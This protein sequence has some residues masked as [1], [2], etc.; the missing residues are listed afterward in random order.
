VEREASRVRPL[1]QLHLIVSEMIDE[2]IRVLVAAMPDPTPGSLLEELFN[3][4]V[5]KQGPRQLHLFCQ[6]ANLA[7]ESFWIFGLD[8][9]PT[10]ASKVHRAKMSMARSVHGCVDCLEGLHEN[11][12]KE[13]S[14]RYEKRGIAP[15]TMDCI[16]ANIVTWMVEQT[17]QQIQNVRDSLTEWTTKS[18]T[19]GKEVKKLLKN[20]AVTLVWQVLNFPQHSLIDIPVDRDFFSFALQTLIRST[21]VDVFSSGILIGLG[22]A[23]YRIRDWMRSKMPD[24]NHPHFQWVDLKPGPVQIFKS[25]IDAMLNTSKGI[26][27]PNRFPHQFNWTRSPEAQWLALE[28]ILSL[29]PKPQK[30]MPNT[31]LANVLFTDYEIGLSII[32]L[33][34][35]LPSNMSPTFQL[36]VLNVMNHLLVGVDREQLSK[37][38]E[39]DMDTWKAVM[40][41]PIVAESLLSMTDDSKRNLVIFITLKYILC[42]T[43]EQPVMASQLLNLLDNP[44]TYFPITRSQKAWI[45]GIV[46]KDITAKPKE[47]LAG[48]IGFLAKSVLLSLPSQ[49]KE[50]NDTINAI[51]LIQGA[52]KRDAKRFGDA[53]IAHLRTEIFTPPEVYASDLWRLLKEHPHTW[54]ME[55]FSV[56]LLDAFKDLAIIPN[57][58]NQMLHTMEVHLRDL[59]YSVTNLFPDLGWNGYV[60]MMIPILVTNNIDIRTLAIKHATTV[61]QA[62]NESMAIRQVV[63][64]APDAAWN[65]VA[66]QCKTLLKLFNLIP[67]EAMDYGLQVIQMIHVMARYHVNALSEDNVK[68]LCKLLVDLL[69]IARS[70]HIEPEKATAPAKFALRIL[71]T[72]VK[73][74][75]MFVEQIGFDEMLVHTSEVAK[76]LAVLDKELLN[77]VINLLVEINDK[78]YAAS[79]TYQLQWSTTDTWQKIKGATLR[80]E[81]G[82]PKNKLLKSLE[83]RKVQVIELSDDEK[84]KEVPM[85]QFLKP[86]PEKRPKSREKS[87]ANVEKRPREKSPSIVRALKDQSRIESRLA[88]VDKKF[89]PKIT[90]RLDSSE[91]EKDSKNML[92]DFDDYEPFEKKPKRTV[93]LLDEKP[94]Q[95]GKARK[96][97][98]EQI[99]REKAKFGS[100]L[101]TFH[102][103]VLQWDFYQSGDKPP[104]N[105]EL[106]SVPSSFGNVDEYQRIFEPLIMLECWQQLQSAREEVIQNEGLD[107]LIGTLDSVAN[108][109]SFHDV[110]FS[111]PTEDF[112]KKRFGENDLL[113]IFRKEAV[114][115]P[116]V[117]VGLENE[118]RL[119]LDVMPKI[120]DKPGA[121]FLGKVQSATVRRDASEV[122]VRVRGETSSRLLK[123]TLQ[124]FMTRVMSLTTVHREYS[125][126]LAVSQFDLLNTILDPKRDTVP[127]TSGIVI[128]PIMA[129]HGV[130]RGQAAA[131]ASALACKKGFTLIQGPPGTGKT[132]TI[133][134]LLGHFVTEVRQR[135]SKY[136]SKIIGKQRRAQFGCHI[137]VCAPSNAGCDEIVRRLKDGV[138][139]K[140][141]TLSKIKIVRIGSA[142][143]I[144]PDNQDVFIDS[145]VDNL[146]LEDKDYERITALTK[147]FREELQSLSRELDQLQQ[148][149]REM[150]DAEEE[151]IARNRARVRTLMSK[152]RD[153][154]D[155]RELNKAGATSSQVELQNLK[156]RLRKS[157]LEDADVVLSTLSGSG[158]DAM[159]KLTHG[160]EIVIIDEAAQA[161]ELSA[162]I[163]LKYN[164]KRVILVGDPQQLPPT[165]LSRV[166]QDLKYETSLFQRIQEAGHKTYM[167]K[168]QY[169]M[170]PAISHFPK[171]FF[172]G[173]QIVDAP[174]IAEKTK[175]P[176][177]V[178]K[179]FAP[180]LFYNVK[181]QEKKLNHSVYNDAEANAVLALVESLL[182]SFQDYNFTSRIGVITPYKRQQMTLRRAF[183]NKFGDEALDYID[184]N[185][186]DGFQGQEKD[187]I[188]FSCV[189]AGSGSGV[190]FLADLRRMNVGLTRAKSSLWVVGHKESLKVNSEWKSLIDDVESRG[191]MREWDKKQFRHQAITPQNLLPHV[192]SAIVSPTKK[193]DDKIFAAIETRGLNVSDKPGLM[194]IEK[195]PMSPL[196]SP[197][198]H[199][200]PASPTP[201][202]S[203]VKRK[204]DIESVV[205]NKAPRI[206]D[207]SNPREVPR[208]ANRAHQSSIPGLLAPPRAR[209]PLEKTGER[210][211]GVHIVLPDTIVVPPPPEAPMVETPIEMSSNVFDAS[212]SPIY[213][214]DPRLQVSPVDPRLQM[215]PVDAHGYPLDPHGY[216]NAGYGRMSPVDSHGNPNYGPMDVHAYPNAGYGQVS[217]TES[218]HGPTDPR[219]YQPTDPRIP[220]PVAF[221][222]DPRFPSDPRFRP[223]SRL[224]L[225]RQPGMQRSA[226]PDARYSKDL[227][228]ERD[229]TERRDRGRD[230]SRNDHVRERRR[231]SREPPIYNKGRSKYSKS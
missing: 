158:H 128:E 25:F 201:T 230:T 77:D 51:K 110:K 98:E 219:F 105:A 137:L 115:D 6:H 159:E 150:L 44:P 182:S 179:E 216:S 111:I 143:A 58:P 74:V 146:L 131:I 35:K 194:I 78:M 66:Y 68:T 147:E 203:A 132:R 227:R 183:K 96:E 46:L 64:K 16:M 122:L 21:R 62:P 5:P 39:V 195:N 28:D 161:V 226:Y 60:L 89:K 198:K 225:D 190:G 9:S 41:M 22:H 199:S 180:Y 100:D 215:S 175:R 47:H 38:Q 160:F 164:A 129:N 193:M 208:H 50:S 92:A 210:V 220:Q 23:D 45:Y 84:P 120:A 1:F 138:K 34:Q 221:P 104:S 211:E 93:Q 24:T 205:P 116:R 141:G 3:V 37:V 176:W 86:E 8:S 139:L 130:N 187:V 97:R 197:L 171:S 20:D 206:G 61:T 7:A 18:E 135:E 95:I 11:S 204:V 134:S 63:E 170:N 173:N 52:L 80:L 185:T 67:A 65:A 152:K 217:P 70:S 31:A 118:G 209:K 162:L 207:V 81:D 169:R 192:G 153:L 212:R 168:T 99:E 117:V 114:H 202:P 126:L 88:S 108:V 181:G 189:R 174:E 101:T 145:L 26:D 59:D 79:E 154:I 54:P 53:V 112:R 85:H 17:R 123:P 71:L 76:W 144:H 127:E 213:P 10:H 142:D 133:L 200:R 223:D 30:G 229:S 186:V 4:V 156:T 43:V 106:Q 222:L 121:Y 224:P 75:E 191:L 125:A 178:K 218:H 14:R 73:D 102:K 40:Q 214:R 12:L 90:P 48:T 184:I 29:I 103:A 188:I 82:K 87:P 167:L 148:D 15:E 91:D 113:L 56:T 163:P 228:V 151:K 136:T 42:L 155:R 157:I 231:W 13:F 177:H 27:A 33:F 149:R 55:T 69:H 83:R 124:W 165:V 49:S 172:Y 166:A 94:V 36:A 2:V 32:Q 119:T 109:D 72:F 57:V 19:F 107:V 140:D 196:Q